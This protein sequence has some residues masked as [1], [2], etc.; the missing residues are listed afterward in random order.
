MCPRS[1]PTHVF[2]YRRKPEHKPPVPSGQ[3]AHV[4]QHTFASHYVMRGGNLKSLQQLLGHSS[5]TVTMRYAHLSPNFHDEVRQL[6]PLSGR[7]F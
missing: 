3:L 5:L 6:N 4:L 1:V 2:D 7:E